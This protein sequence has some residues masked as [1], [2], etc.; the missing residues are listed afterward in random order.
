[1]VYFLLDDRDMENQYNERSLKAGIW[2]VLSEIFVRGASFF[3]TPIY[4]RLLPTEVFGNVRVFES[5]ILI[6]VPVISL[7]LFNS[8]ERAKLDFGKK[9]DAYI[10]SIVTL[11][12][13]MFAGTAI[14]L[15]IWREKIQHILSFSDSMFLILI[16]YGFS[17]VCILCMQKRERQLLHYKSNALL[18]FLTVL[19]SVVI[20]IVLLI[21]YGNQ[22]QE[23]VLT[24]LRILGFYVPLIILG[25]GV[26]VVI[27]YRGRTLVNI[28][29]WRYG[30]QYSIP[31]IIYAVSAQV[32]YQSDKIMIQTICGKSQAGIYSLATTIVYIIDV[33]SN[34]LQGAWIP[35]LFEKLDKRNIREI[36]KVWI[37]MFLGLS[38]MSWGVV[39][40]APE[41]VWFLGGNNYDDAK[42][43]L[44]S[45]LSAGVFQ[46]TMM[47]FVA[48]EKFYKKT[49]YSGVAGVL[50]AV[51]NIGLNVVFI[52]CFGYQAAAYTTAFS[53]LVSVVIHYVLI[54][55]YVSQ[56][57]PIQILF[58]ICMSIWMINIASMM[59]YALPWWIRLGLLSSSIMLIGYLM[60]KKIVA[61]V[62]TVFKKKR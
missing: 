40:I 7:S 20:S 60:R 22:A 44:G 32:L 3:A 31:L 19:P 10:S 49:E 30:V 52:N 21:C 55:R 53:Y 16:P 61:A 25:M 35:W 1:M 59:L 42:W 50:S 43:L 13:L 41:L 9:Y 17:Y 18:S 8:V 38:I 57:I 33:L 39:M 28:E 36:Q 23:D 14:A 62:S 24:D 27:Y 12:L 45:M 29:Y 4:T 37:W 34:A 47:L 6:L 58:M 15:C 56:N 11:M 2:Y 48:L 46:F 54:R 5:W 26:M 51:I